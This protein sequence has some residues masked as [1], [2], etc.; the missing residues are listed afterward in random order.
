M[1][2]TRPSLS[3][4]LVVVLAAA[5]GIA[6]ANS[7]YA[8]PLLAVIRHSLHVGPGAAGL[9]V[10]ASQV[11]YALGLVFLL[12]LGDLVERRR[13]VVAM[14]VV[15]AAALAG[16]AASPDL[17]VLFAMVAIV[18]VNSVVAQVL[19]AFTA[20]LA[21]DRDRGRMVGTVMSGLLLGVLLAR[22]VAGYVAQAWSWRGVYLVAA[23]AMLAV[24]VVLA[25][26]LPTY[27]ERHDLTYP[28]VLGSVVGIFR[29]EPV[30]RWRALFGLLSFASFSVLWTSLA[31]LLSGSP[32]HYGS[33]TIGLFGLVGA[34]GAGMAS[35]A[36]RLAD[37]GW[38]GVVTVATAALVLV[39]FVIFWSDPR[40]LALL[41]VGIVVL[42]LGCQGIHVTNQ[43]QIYRLR[44]RA[45]SRVNASYMTAYFVGGTVGSVGSA[46]CFQSFGWSGVSALGTALGSLLLLLA[47]VEWGLRARR[48]S[49]PRLGAGAG[50]VTGAATGAGSQ[51]PATAGTT[52]SV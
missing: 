19:V 47:V 44:P 8:Q 29:A 34:A 14:S 26:A 13:L 16:A 36:G 40:S 28:A 7:Y 30:L 9:L 17:G 48:G 24:A 11:G 51:P 27:R 1:A 31:F 38:H 2:A 39:A 6:V 10:T 50:A 43:S 5:T 33:G 42:D 41:V 18:G 22:T 4:G 20:S 3:H 23:I 21:S 49:S 25:R 52:L 46:M 12:P 15:A 45:H 37:R 35:L 32:Y